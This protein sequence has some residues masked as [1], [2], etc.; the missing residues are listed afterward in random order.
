MTKKC[1][2]I[3]GTSA[4]QI[5]YFMAEFERKFKGVKYDIIDTNETRTEVALSISRLST[6]KELKLLRLIH[7]N[8]M[9]YYVGTIKA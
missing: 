3:K 6:M 1:F 9:D 2:V 8:D 4:W 5:G 7:G